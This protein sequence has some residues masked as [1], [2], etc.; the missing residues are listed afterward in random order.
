MELTKEQEQIKL[1]VIKNNMVYQEE[2]DNID[3][4]LTKQQIEE[5]IKTIN[6]YLFDLLFK[7]GMVS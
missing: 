4:N 6:K 3:H 5:Q 1:N 2:L 7:L